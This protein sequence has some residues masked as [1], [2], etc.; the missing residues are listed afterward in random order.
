MAETGEL[1]TLMMRYRDIFPQS[2][3]AVQDLL[4]ILQN[5]R[6]VQAGNAATAVAAVA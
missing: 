5:A 2:V 3:K 6:R 1:A 4:F